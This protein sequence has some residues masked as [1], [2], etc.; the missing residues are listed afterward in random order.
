MSEGD[1]GR[2]ET[3]EG[4]VRFEDAY[5]KGIRTLPAPTG[6]HDV[7]TPF[8]IVR[9]YEF[10]SGDGLPIVLLPG[11]NGTVVSLAPNIPDLAAHRRVFAVDSLGEPGASVQTAPIRNADDQ[12][13]WLDATLAGLGIESAHVVGVSIGGWAACNLAVRAPGRVASLSLLDPANTLARLSVGV[14]ARS[15]L[16]LLP[17][18]ADWAVPRFLHWVDGQEGEDDPEA[19]PVGHVI[20][21]G[22]REFESELPTPEYPDDDELRSID[23][24]T[25]ALIAGRSVMHDPEDAFERANKVLRHGQV[26][27][28]KDA[29][30][31][32][33]GQYAR[34]VNR[35][36]L[37]FT[38]EVGAAATSGI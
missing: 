13:A 28:W 33:A 16:T 14:I 6:T 37:R 22:M 30:H 4:R 27:M 31:A 20:A 12:A 35:R 34:E 15:V 1:I 25:L 7:T 9:V 11:R 32:I 36:I 24:P 38:D 2:Y 10:G 26:E 8:G 29:T 18:T 17:V 3:A 19:N 21:E 5:A 23:V